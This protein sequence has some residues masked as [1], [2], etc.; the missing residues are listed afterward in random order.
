MKYSGG[1][2]SPILEMPACADKGEHKRGRSIFSF[3]TS[4]MCSPRAP[5]ATA[6]QMSPG[7]S[8]DR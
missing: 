7:Q 6:A 1:K 2:N 5:T 4:Q 8:P 3:F